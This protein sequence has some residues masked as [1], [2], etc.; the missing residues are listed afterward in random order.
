MGRFQKVAQVVAGVVL[1][2]TFVVLLQVRSQVDTASKTDVARTQQTSEQNQQ[3]LDRVEEGV[4]AIE[5][6]Y[7]CLV[8]LLLVEPPDRDGI[9]PARFAEVCLVDL[10]EAQLIAASLEAGP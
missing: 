5:H 8:A 10:A 3:I 7:R 2:V 1:V 4:D 6:G 9:D